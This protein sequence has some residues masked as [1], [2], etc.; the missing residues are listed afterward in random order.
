MKFKFTGSWKQKFFGVI[1]N[2]YVYYMAWRPKDCSRWGYIEE[3]YDG[4]LYEFSI[5][6]FAFIWHWD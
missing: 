2:D 6:R 1:I 4:P 3:W 5:G